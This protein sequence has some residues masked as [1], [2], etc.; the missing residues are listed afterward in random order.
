MLWKYTR[1]QEHNRVY[2]IIQTILDF[3]YEVNTHM[4]K[5]LFG[6]ITATLTLLP[7]N[8]IIVNEYSDI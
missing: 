4:N 6:L 8:S 3:T 5:E 7:S 2:T 1:Q